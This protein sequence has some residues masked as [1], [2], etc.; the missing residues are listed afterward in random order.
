MF[1]KNVI[2]ITIGVLAVIFTPILIMNLAEDL[3]KTEV[4]VIQ[5]PLTGELTAHTEPG[6][7]WQGF[8]K[9]TKMPRR[10]QFSFSSHSDQGKTVDESIITQFNDGG[11][12]NISGV[13]NWAVPLKHDQLIALVRDFGSYEAVEQQLIKPSMQKVVFNVGPTMS[14]AESAA[15]KRADIPKYMDDQLLHGPYLMETVEASVP[16]IITGREKKTNVLKIV[17]G[18]DG[19]PV[20]EAKS[21]ITEYGIQ[22]QPVTINAVNY[23]KT[24]EG[25][26]KERQHAITQV[27]T[28]IANAKKAEQDAITIEQQG[29]AAAAKAKWEQEQANAKEVA[30]SEKEVI[31][32]RNGAQ[33]AEQYKRKLIL[34]GEGEATKKRMIMEADGA[35]DKKLEAYVK[36]NG[37]YANAIQSAHPGAWTPAVQMGTTG[38]SG[39]NAHALMDMFAAKAAKDLGVDLQAAGRANTV[40]K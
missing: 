32:A 40:K 18:K 22:L 20:R 14:S 13:M 3:D 35:L 17:I 21:Q 10:L 36:V 1:G 38:N 12:A 28:A 19:K 30:I 26:I 23:D 33:A 25:Q 4:M 37:F 27:Q 39:S 24:V 16:D 34:E 29:K 2:S 31:V 6:V 7:K 11:R 9:V 8:G 15:E 5:S